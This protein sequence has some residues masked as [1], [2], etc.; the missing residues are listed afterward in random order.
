M[1]TAAT[2]APTV[3]R[4]SSRRQQSYTAPVEDRPRR[5]TSVSAKPSATPSGPSRTHSQAHSQA[6]PLSS[7]QQQVPAGVAR[8]DYETTSVVRPSSSS[9]RSSSRD[10]SHS[11]AAPKRTDSTRESRH[12]ASKPSHSRNNSRMS[13]SEAQATA[14]GSITNPT[15]SGSKILSDMSSHGGGS[16]AKRRT[17]IT[18]QTGE[19]ILGKT[20]GAGSMGKVKLAKNLETGEQVRPKYQHSSTGILFSDPFYR[21]LSRL[22]QDNLRK[23]ITIVEIGN[24]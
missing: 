23:S 18:A 4:S 1:S 15:S 13:T 12:T 6:R 3:V 9:R 22:Y 2:T 8:R 5:A 21:L 19:W 16:T 11:T 20:I 24:V 17:T 7:S 10:R 14:G